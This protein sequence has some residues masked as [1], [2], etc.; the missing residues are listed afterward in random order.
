MQ[1]ISQEK[2]HEALSKINCLELCKKLG[3]SLN[4]QNKIYCIWHP[5]NTPSLQVYPN[6]F[7][8]FGCGKNA[9]AIHFIRHLKNLSFIQALEYLSHQSFSP[10][11]SQKTF[12]EATFEEALTVPDFVERLRII[13]YIAAYFSSLTAIQIKQ[14]KI[15]RLISNWFDERG[16]DKKIILPKWENRF[17][18]IDKERIPIVTQLLKENFKNWRRTNLFNQNEELKWISGDDYAIAFPIWNAKTITSLRLRN[19]VGGTPK[20]IEMSPITGLPSSF[21]WMGYYQIRELNVPYKVVLVEGAPDMLAGMQYFHEEKN[22]FVV[23]TGNVKKAEQL[24][25]LQLLK[26]NCE[27]LILA[28]DNDPVGLKT[29]HNVGR[30][31][32]ILGFPKISQLIFNGKDLNEFVKNSKQ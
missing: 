11:A 3:F 4:S 8:C 6:R 29:T 5:E 13:N 31:A 19:V 2:V 32:T 1:Q 17:F 30:N 27:E 7:H 28:F 14:R 24:H 9:N 25:N 16:L 20:D 26:K 22:I 18:F 23:S 10:I 15:Q 21:G 12:R